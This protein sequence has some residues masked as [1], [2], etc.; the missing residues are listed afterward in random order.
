[1]RKYRLAEA[2]GDALVL[3]LGLLYLGLVTGLY[4]VTFWLPQIVKGFGGVSNLEVGFIV[5]VPNLAAAIGMVLWT[6]HSDRMRE[7]P[8]HVALPAF[9]GCLGLVAGAT[10]SNPIL[11]TVALGVA[12]IGIYA[13]IATS[14]TLPTAFLSGTAAAGGLALINAI[15]NL[16]GFLGP[17]FMGWIR[18]ATGDYSIALLTIGIGLALAG[19][20]ALAMRRAVADEHPGTGVQS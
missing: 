11:S 18:T 1:V 12:L 5:A 13:A 20:I 14:W 6:R 10:V 17:Y 19:L 15:G 9:V 16:G 4:A 2:L 7:R 8:W 3:R